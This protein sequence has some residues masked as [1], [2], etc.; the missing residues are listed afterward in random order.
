MEIEMRELFIAYLQSPSQE[1]YHRVRNALITS[2][3]YNPYSMEIEEIQNLL[4]TKKFTQAITVF[5]KTI[6]NLLLSPR[7][8]ML[9][10]MAY[11]E[12]EKQE[13]AKMEAVIYKR[14]LD[15]I[16]STGD[17]S[18]EHPYL[19][20][21]VSDEYDILFALQKDMESQALCEINNHHCDVMTLTDGGE[22]V[23]DITDCYGELARQFSDP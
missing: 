21:R 15:G 12:L 17:G 14:C 7:A 20:T 9:A 10:S 19:V 6:P 1:T 4:E 2:D 13:E 22:I 18:R 16:L 3:S 23:F 11:K 8:H 5:Q